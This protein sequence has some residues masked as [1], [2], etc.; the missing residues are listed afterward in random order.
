MTD[1]SF[2]AFFIDLV[3]QFPCLLMAEDSV[4]GER[5]RILRVCSFHFFPES[6]VQEN[7]QKDYHHHVQQH[8]SVSHHKSVPPIFDRMKTVPHIHNAGIEDQKNR[9]YGVR[10]L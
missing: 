9:D 6:G 7:G 4:N 1:A 8:H 2:C 3:K 10:K 5:N